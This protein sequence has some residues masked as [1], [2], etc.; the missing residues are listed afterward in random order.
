MLYSNL[1]EGKRNRAHA[2]VSHGSLSQF[3][4]DNRRTSRRRPSA[5]IAPFRS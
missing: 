5:R 4:S 1:C 3:T 2:Y